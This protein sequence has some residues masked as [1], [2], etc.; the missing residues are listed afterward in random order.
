MSV[1]EFCDKHCFNK[2]DYK[3]ILWMLCACNQRFYVHNGCHNNENNMSVSNTGCP[4]SKVH[5]PDI[6]FAKEKYLQSFWNSG[7]PM[8]KHSDRT[9]LRAF[10]SSVKSVN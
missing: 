7:V 1:I 3:G 8:A 2:T 5:V 6:M 10:K 9:H 4:I